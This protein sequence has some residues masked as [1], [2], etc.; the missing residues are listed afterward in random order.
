MTE[1]ISTPQT[2]AGSRGA[3]AQPTE[4]D[5]DRTLVIVSDDGAIYKLLKDDW[6]QEKFR[7]KDDAGT[8]GIVNQ[9]EA[10]GSYLAFVNKNLALAV[11]CC[12]TVVNLRSVLKGAGILP[13]VHWRS[14][15]HVD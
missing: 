6:Q 8:T 13:Q 4:A 10:F 11:G 15:Q 14:S 7:M 12:C 5:P 9:L 2:S 3:K 1:A